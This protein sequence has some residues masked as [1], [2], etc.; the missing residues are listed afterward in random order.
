MDA[1]LVQAL[2]RVI[3][4]PASPVAGE[5]QVPPPEHNDSVEKDGEPVKNG[6][7]WQNRKTKQ[8]LQPRV[9]QPR[10][11]PTRMEG[12]TLPV[13]RLQKDLASCSICLVDFVEA[14]RTDERAAGETEDEHALRL[15]GCGH[16]FH[17]SI[18][19]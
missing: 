19:S 4:L 1:T 11:Q 13:I 16:V 7:K 14:V 2:S 8:T 10:V 12:Y 17:V 18:R 3:Y 15:L 9:P 6:F 5:S